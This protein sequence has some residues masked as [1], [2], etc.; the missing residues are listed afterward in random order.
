[1]A[2]GELSPMDLLIETIAQQV[3][4]PSLPKS[5]AR[6]ALLW[7]LEQTPPPPEGHAV[8]PWLL[9][10]IRKASEETRRRLGLKPPATAEEGGMN[11]LIGE[12]QPF[13][14]AHACIAGMLS[15]LSPDHALILRSLELSNQS[16][17][18]LAVKL[19]TTPNAIRVRARQARQALYMEMIAWSRQR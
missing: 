19:E 11:T 12:A 4:L 14:K 2:P 5:A 17:T 9:R 6:G 16:P 8:S 10:C 3:G 1:M 15:T 18:Q 13:Q 7:V